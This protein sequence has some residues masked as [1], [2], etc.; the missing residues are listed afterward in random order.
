V[1]VLLATSALGADLR[2]AVLAALGLS[3]A[4]LAGI[5]YEAARRSG[6]PVAAALGWAAGTALLG[7]AVIALKLALH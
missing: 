4:L 2:V 7:V 5:G 1:I 3:T 6:A